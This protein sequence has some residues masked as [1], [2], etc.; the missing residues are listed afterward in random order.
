MSKACRCLHMFQLRNYR[1]DVDQT[2]SWRALTKRAVGGPSPNVQLEGPHQMCSW[3]AL[4][5][6]CGTKQVLTSRLKLFNDLYRVIII[7]D[8]YRLL[9]P[10]DLR[11]CPCGRITQRQRVTQQENRKKLQT[12]LVK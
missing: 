4:T 5:K 10:R 1:R 9:L 11:S 8:Q 6:Y 2:C 7:S 12:T 3:K